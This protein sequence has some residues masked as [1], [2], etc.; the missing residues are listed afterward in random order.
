MKVQDKILPPPQI[1]SVSEILN[2]M[3]VTGSD[4]RLRIVNFATLKNLISIP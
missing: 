4:N 3:T 1:I 2:L